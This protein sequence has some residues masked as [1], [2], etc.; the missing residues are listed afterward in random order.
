MSFMFST[1]SCDKAAVTPPTATR[2]PAVVTIAA[3]N[4]I[5]AAIIAA[6]TAPAAIPTF[7]TFFQNLGVLAFHLFLI[8]LIT[9]LI[10]A[11]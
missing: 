9:N 1:V 8:V 6:P 7:C 2:Y 5:G 11:L 4:A 10:M 3:G